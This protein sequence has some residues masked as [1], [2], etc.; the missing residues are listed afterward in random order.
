ML[1]VCPTSFLGHLPEIV[2]DIG[3]T[4]SVDD[5]S[6]RFTENNNGHIALKGDWTNLGPYILAR[7]KM[8][9]QPMTMPM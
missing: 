9:A 3:E 7:W 6:N 2:D 4:I 8:M 1:G 5:Q